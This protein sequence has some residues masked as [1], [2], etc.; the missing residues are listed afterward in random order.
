MVSPQLPNDVALIPGQLCCIG[1][2]D[3]VNALYFDKDVQRR[4]G[5]AKVYETDIGFFVAPSRIHLGVKSKEIAWFPN[6]GLV[7][8]YEGQLY[9]RTK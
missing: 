3:C 7:V 2:R 6:L 9:P 5:F 8:F 4:N 1:D